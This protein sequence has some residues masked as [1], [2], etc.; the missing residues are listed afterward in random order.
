M[1]D[2]QELQVKINTLRGLRATYISRTSKIEN[3]TDS[4]DSIKMVGDA[5]PID[6]A[7]NQ[8]MTEARRQAIYDACSPVADGLIEGG[9]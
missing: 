7:T 3:V 1:I 4:L 8:P 9:N 5:M 2:A 6:P